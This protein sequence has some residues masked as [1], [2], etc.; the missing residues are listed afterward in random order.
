MVLIRKLAAVKVKTRF[1]EW[2]LILSV[3]AV[4]VNT[5]SII[6]CYMGFFKLQ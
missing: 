2:P 4:G 6:F 5:L 3:I 1:I